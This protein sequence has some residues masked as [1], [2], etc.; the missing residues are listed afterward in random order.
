MDGLERMDGRKRVSNMN[1]DVVLE[2][3]ITPFDNVIIDREIND[4]IA[5]SYWNLDDIP[6]HVP[7]RVTYNRVFLISQGVGNLRID[8]CDFSIAGPQILLIAKGQIYNFDQGSKIEGYELLF[9]DCFWERTPA[10]AANCKAVLFNNASANQQIHINEGD[11]ALLRPLFESFYQEFAS[12]GYVNKLDALAAY[13]KIIMIKIANTNA[14]LLDAFDTV[15]KQ[16]YRSFLELVST[17]FRLNHDVA[18]YAK[19]LHITSRRLTDICNRC[20]GR[21]AKAIIDGQIIAESKR[22]LQFSSQS[23]K[24]IA[25]S[26]NFTSPDQF[27]HFFKHN[28]HMAPNDYR[29]CFLSLGM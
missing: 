8:G 25:Y 18:G 15:D 4:S 24:E 7:R 10:S 11:L 20:G 19:Q 22:L 5:M 12:E 28:T 17:H 14:A 2:K 16:L 9:G 6:V 27:S 29:T 1:G 23:I 26:L 3:V 13:L 21:G